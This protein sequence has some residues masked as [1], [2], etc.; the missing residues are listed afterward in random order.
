MLS[1]CFPVSSEVKNKLLDS[2]KDIKL[3][4][5]TTF[6]DEGTDLNKSQLGGIALASA[7]AIKNPTLIKSVLAEVRKRLHGLNK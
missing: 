6:T 7:Y 1:Q 2:A 5:A 3:N 4:I